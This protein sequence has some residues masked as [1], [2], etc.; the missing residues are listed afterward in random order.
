[1]API[2]GTLHFFFAHSCALPEEIYYT[3]APAANLDFQ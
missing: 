1:V 3:I 2:T